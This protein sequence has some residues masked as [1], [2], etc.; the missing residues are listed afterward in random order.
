[1]KICLISG[2]ANLP[3]V[4]AHKI[5]QNGYELYSI[6]LK[7][8]INKS[9]KKISK[10]Y[11]ISN[12][13]SFKRTIE[14]L[15]ENEINDVILCGKVDHRILLKYK[16]TE[17]LLFDKRPKPIF[18][19]LTE[20]LSQNKINVLSFRTFVSDLIAQKGV[21]THKQ[22]NEEQYS[23]IELGFKIAKELIK[24]DIGSTV[25]MKCGCVISVEGIDGTDMT[26]LRGGKLAGNGT[27]VVKVGREGFD[28]KFDPAVVGLRTIQTMHKVKASVLAVESNNV[29]IL[30]QPEIFK[31]ADDR[32]ISII[33]I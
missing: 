3:E 32:N 13:F 29:I 31:Y 30:N 6:L 23:D 14:F 26:I 5:I 7:G 24:C 12:I 9:L 16:N 21:L 2:S 11:I 8:F 1:M 18:S 28:W 20:L 22:P 4:I 10:K 15:K 27:V 17:A 19:Y 33:G 25:I